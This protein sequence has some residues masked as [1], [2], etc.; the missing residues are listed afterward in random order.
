MVP[1]TAVKT[2]L[3]KGEL[4]TKINFINNKVPGSSRFSN[5]FRSV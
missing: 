2:G 5:G 4:H 3:Q 1:L